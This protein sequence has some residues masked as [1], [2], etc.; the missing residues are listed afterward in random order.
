MFVAAACHV[1]DPLDPLKAPSSF[2]PQLSLAS[3]AS[4]VSHTSQAKWPFLA[5]LHI[6]TALKK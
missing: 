4:Y 6:E 2:R 1:W 3:L 5:A